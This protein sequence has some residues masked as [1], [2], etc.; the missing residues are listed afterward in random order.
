MINKESQIY[1][2]I[3]R[4]FNLKR[5]I[6]FFKEFSLIDVLVFFST[7]LIFLTIWLPLIL[8]GL[9]VNGIITAIVGLCIAS[10]LLIKIDIRIYLFIYRLLKFSLSK[11][12]IESVNTILGIDNGNIIKLNNEYKSKKIIYRIIGNDT[13]F[14]DDNDFLELSNNFSRFIKEIDNSYFIKLDGKISF[15]DSINFLKYKNQL[16]NK[17]KNDCSKIMSNEIKI[18]LEYLNDLKKD[19]FN[20]VQ[21]KYFLVLDYID[22]I[23]MEDKLKD[24]QMLANSSGLDLVIP[25]NDEIKEIVQEHFFENT[26]LYEGWK[27]IICE[28]NQY[29]ISNT[30]DMLKSLGQFSKNIISDNEKKY[31]QDKF[32]DVNRFK[33]K[34]KKYYC[35]FVSVSNFPFSVDRNFLE[36]LFNKKGASLTCFLENVENKSLER[37]LNLYKE[38]CY[39]KAIIEGSNSI[40][41]K[42]NKDEYFAVEKILEDVYNGARMKNVSLIF[43]L[44]AE[45]KNELNRL[46]RSFFKELTRQN[47]TFN[48]LYFNQINALKTFIPSN[49][50]LLKKENIINNLID[51]TFAFGYPFTQYEL[52]HKNSLVFG[53]NENKTPVFLDWT[54]RDKSNPSSS[55]I[56]LGKTGAGKTT[57]AKRIIKNQIIQD[58]YKLYVI[59]PENEYGEL[60]EKFGGEVI[61]LSSGKYVINPFDLS[62]NKN[63]T[64]EEFENAL[65]EKQLFLETFFRIIFEDRLPI[66]EIANIIQ[67]IYEMYQKHKCNEFTFNDV[68]KELIKSKKVSNST[69]S[70]FRL[71]CKSYSKNI[72]DGAYS[73]IW[74][75]KTN[76]N[77]KNNYIVFELRELLA[78]GSNNPIVKAQ[79]YLTLQYIN[80]KVLNNRDK[81]DNRYINII[82]DEAH[83]LMDE[84][85]IQVVNFTTEMFKR[86]R[87]YNGMMMII[88]QNI[89]DF[90]KPSIEQYTKALINNAHYILLHT[91]KPQEINDLND[92]FKDDGGLNSVERDFL[93]NGLSGQCLMFYGNVRTKINIKE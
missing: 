33:S 78:K 26:K 75:K 74:D 82:L 62:L 57:T 80:N 35:A 36:P 40:K 9:V 70:Q 42:Q 17:D 44:Q 87:K 52:I 41:N 16:L 93:I 2:N 29:D 51:S 49:I 86:I 43:K 50:N 91:I 34:S 64:K 61:N 18:T 90:H 92:L 79:I 21:S 76:I 28:T 3:P 8:N 5:G 14:H 68:I 72:K 13:S 10:I 6:K 39:S 73:S 84:K 53:I 81:F 59:D 54:F 65:S 31:I 46:M 58:K 22:S 20:S 77:M 71:F 25:T 24:L 38:E 12:K 55:T 88:T 85:Y 7:N 32:N 67:V 15:D 19:S 69:I 45:S 4:D 48:R 47:F 56:L 1:K 23:K 37:K 60:V 89:G 66:S 11:K 83:L 63:P 27:N 30:A